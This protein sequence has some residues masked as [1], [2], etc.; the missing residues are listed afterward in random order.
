[1]NRYLAIRVLAHLML[2]VCLVLWGV[3]AGL[4]QPR[5]IID[6]F[7]EGILFGIGLLICSVLS[8]LYPRD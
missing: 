7:P 6:Y 4:T 2:I 3:W 5:Y 1:M 8:G